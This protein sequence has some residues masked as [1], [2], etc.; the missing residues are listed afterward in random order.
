MTPLASQPISARVKNAI[1]DE[2]SPA[3]RAQND[4]KHQSES[5]PCPSL[6]S[7]NPCS[8]SANASLARKARAW[9]AG[10]REMPWLSLV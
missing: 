4:A 2:P 8:S 10:V 9:A 5:T 3:A 6:I 1:D 7:T